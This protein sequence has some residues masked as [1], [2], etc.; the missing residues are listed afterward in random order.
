MRSYPLLAVLL[1]LAASCYGENDISYGSNEADLS[2][3]VTIDGRPAAGITVVAKSGSDSRTVRTDENGRY[4]LRQIR[5]GL[6]TLSLRGLPEHVVAPSQQVT[7]PSADVVH[8]NFNA[9]SPTVVS[10]LV[11]WEYAYDE[12]IGLSGVSAHMEAP[13]FP[14]ADA[15]TAADGVY[16]FLRAPGYG[17]IPVVLGQLPGGLTFRSGQRWTSNAPTVVLDTAFATYQPSARLEVRVYVDGELDDGAVVHLATPIPVTSRARNFKELPVMPLE[18]SIG[19]VPDAVTFDARTKTVQLDP[20]GSIRVIFTGYSPGANRVPVPTIL[21]PANGATFAVGTPIT[22]RGAATDFEDGALTGN[23]FYWNGSDG[24]LGRGEV[25]TVDT[26]PVGQHRIVLHA[27]DSRGA[28]RWVDIS[29]TVV[30]APTA[31]RISGTVT[32]DGAPANTSVTAGARVELSTTPMRSTTTDAQGR[33]AFENVPAGTYTVT[34]QPV[35]CAE[36]EVSARS[37]AVVMGAT[38]VVNFA[39][40]YVD[41]DEDG[42]NASRTM[43]ARRTVR[44]RPPF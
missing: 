35:V 41:E 14:V 8:V 5:F 4:E 39:G 24:P 25:L 3:R 32:V 2:G 20:G 6:V 31:G 1:L 37:A 26:L 34:L 28:D 44:G 9:L 18:V 40:V 15:T 16:R 43:R 33:Y 13:P 36:F 7:L 29:I 11:V 27:V 23:A 12:S 38:T 21:A 10:G 30:P 22:F 19:G 42:S 17:P